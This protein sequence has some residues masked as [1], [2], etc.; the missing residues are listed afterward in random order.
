MDELDR[1][2]L[3]TIQ[4]D[5]PL[6]PRP[7]QTIGKRLGISEEKCIDLLKILL[8]EGILRAIRMVIS[9]KK[10]GYSTVLVGMKVDPDQIETIASEISKIEEVTHNYARQGSFNL[11]FTLIYNRPEEKDLLFTSL[12]TMK[13]VEDIREFKAE[14]TYKIGLV[15]DV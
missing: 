7:Y 9:W 5:F 6:E 2:L 10:I 1:S 11:W 3:N 4:N 12:R 8:S 14:K 13:G 15:L